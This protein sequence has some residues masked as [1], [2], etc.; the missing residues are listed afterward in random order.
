MFRLGA[1]TDEISEDFERALDIVGKWGLQDVEIHTLWDT[2]VEALTDEQTT[3]L[4]GILQR[5]QLHLAVLDSTAFLRCP[6]RG[7]TIP[8]NW[9]KRFQS[10]G[11]TYDVH[12]SALERCLQIAQRLKVPC[13]RIFGF[14]GEGELTQEVIREIVDRLQ[15][16]IELAAQAGVVLVLENCPHTYLDHTR[17]VL[18]VLELAD[19]PYLRLLWDPSNAYRSGEKDV[20]DLVNEVSP[21]LAHMHV[22][23]VTLNALATRGREYVVIEKGDIDYRR[24]LGEV[25]AAGYN[26]IVSLEPHYALPKSGREGA[27]RESF[28]SLRRIVD[29]LEQ[30]V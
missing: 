4:Q 25:A 14:W 2:H 12:L 30:R 9:S 10:I 6:L 24:L 15:A 1:I 17:H 29:S 19:S 21:F 22:K 3:Y 8:E 7:V 18:R 5:R 20:A 23:G 11:G 26:G 28:T 16:P 27:A 13:V